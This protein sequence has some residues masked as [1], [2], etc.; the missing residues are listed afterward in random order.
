MRKEGRE[1]AAR[2]RREC[3]MR[4]RLRPQGVPLDAKGTGRNHHGQ[5][6]YRVTVNKALINKFHI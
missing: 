2:R 3:T 1:N 5:P 4:A 6:K